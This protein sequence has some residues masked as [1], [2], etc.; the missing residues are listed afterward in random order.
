MVK[1]REKPALDVAIKYIQQRNFL[2]NSGIFIWSASTIINAFRVY[3]PSI[4]RIFDKIRDKL[5]TPEEQAVI[6]EVY[7]DCENISVDYAIMEKADEIYVCPAKLPDG[8]TLERGAHC[9][10]RVRRTSMAMPSSARKSMFT[11]RRIQSSTY[12]ARKR[13]SFR[14][15][16][17][18]SWL[19][20]TVCC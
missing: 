7:P 5:G 12:R 14:D 13:L 19:S 20:T 4:A 17:D 3:E 15:L 1:F 2:W 6:N 18:I 11:T 16:T 8:V 10:F 9:S